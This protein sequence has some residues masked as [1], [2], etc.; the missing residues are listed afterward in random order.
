MN[1]DEGAPLSP[2]PIKK[3]SPLKRLFKV[4]F[5]ALGI[6]LILTLIPVILVFIYQKEI[7][8]A[9][10]S[11]INTH[12][13]TK[14]YIN[15]D[16]IDITILK[17]FPNA[18]LVFKNVSILGSL[19]DLQN[20]TLLNAKSIYLLFNAKDIWNKKYNI[21][22]INIESSAL[23]LFVN[24]KGEPNYDIWED[25]ADSVK[26]EDRSASF[27]LNKVSFYDF[28]FNYKNSQ[29]KT[30]VISTFKDVIFS[31][32]F[33]DD[34]Y[35]LDVKANGFIS[36]IKSGKKNYIKNKNL[37]IELSAQVKKNRY[38]ITNAEVG[39][40]K[41]FFTID[42]FLENNTDEMPAEINL[43][44]K[45]IDV[46][47]VLSLLPEKFHEKIKD[48]Q[49]DGIFYSDVT[50]AGNLND[51]NTLDIKANFGTSKASITH[52]PTKTTLR[53][54][55]F[56][57]SFEKKKFSPEI[58]S[59]KEIKAHQ[60]KNFV[61]GQFSLRNFANPYLKIK[62]EGNYNLTDF[63]AL[64]PVDTISSSSGTIDF[65]VDANI[66]LNDAKAL[67][68]GT[69]S[70][71]GK[72]DLKE[73]L[74]VF[75][76]EHTLQIPGGQILIDNENLETKN[77]TLLH[78]KSSLEVS[79]KATN[80]LNYILKP[81]QALRVELDVKSP[82]ID[83]DDFIL[84][85]S[86]KTNG[87][88]INENPLNLKDNISA[89]LKLNVTEV[90]FRKFKARNLQGQLEIKNKRL[91]AN[92]L[93]FE[94]FNGDITLTGIA[95][96]SKDDKLKITGNVKLVDANIRQ[97]FTQLNNFGQTAIEA[98]NMNGK[99]T[100][101][102]D[103][104]ASWNDHLQCDLSSIIASA[105][106]TITNGELVDYKILEHLAE[107]VE[108]KELKQV[109]FANLQTHVDIKNKTVYISKTSLKNSALD[110]E[111]SG[112]QTFDNVIDY[113]I[114]LRLGDY[115]AKRPCKNKQLDEELSEME[116]DPENK[117]CVFLHMTGTIDKP[118]I[119]YDRKAMKQKI[120]E[121]LKEE[122]NTLKKLLHDEFGLFKKDTVSFKN[123]DKKQDQKFNIDFNQKKKDDDKKKED[124]D[125]F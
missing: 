82:F 65:S 67:Q 15:P 114:K 103:F 93:S 41:L 92:N 76:G 110:I 90:V 49:S 13:K 81:E 71:I 10:V 66:N 29:N 94:A 11:E 61:S 118:I 89:D 35:K 3:K 40:N 106:V 86:G 43:K 22:Q 47:S 8:N 6:L 122:K 102:L 78:G 97:L 53:D 51:Y 60:N 37:A 24:A 105:D 17:T 20:D 73:V 48:Y 64:V 36:S 87:Q 1:I 18:A 125:D 27:K 84:P 83:A 39:L 120:K 100:T 30:K 58:L 98:Q 91:L 50:I 74:I 124:D 25:Y 79:G 5:W 44:G 45:N 7:K 38:A 80:F 2:D 34:A 59:L 88:N 75:K 54:V 28:S 19:S 14:V 16:D 117:R 42:G 57:G 70:A 111:L 101:Q 123:N 4:L 96:A 62:A 32:N 112:S 52:S 108:L 72:I 109:K 85:E 12:L 113:R 104:S 107:Y 23:R 68:I 69:S 115:L 121:D 31:G 21:Q 55:S 33:S 26:K 95:D 56:A 116:N 63:F 99:A 119:T 77:L 46:Q 9:I